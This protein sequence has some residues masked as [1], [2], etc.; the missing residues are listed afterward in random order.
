SLCKANKLDLIEDGNVWMIKARHQDDLRVHVT[1]GDHNGYYQVDFEEQELIAAIM[2]VAQF[3]G[4][5]VL[6]PSTLHDADDEEEARIRR[7]QDQPITLRVRNATPDHVLRELAR[8]GNMDIEVIV[9]EGDQPAYKFT[10]R[11]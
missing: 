1:K 10:Y 11:K 9:P 7:I 8:L 4:A 3:T 6:I 5:Q 2:E